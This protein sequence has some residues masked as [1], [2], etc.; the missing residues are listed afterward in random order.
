MASSCSVVG[1]EQEKGQ[2]SRTAPWMVQRKGVGTPR[3][4]G[5]RLGGRAGGRYRETGG[6]KKELSVQM[7]SH[8][9][10]SAL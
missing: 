1:D 7:R 5:V 2:D 4:K 6:R 10:S 8:S 3:R 9:F